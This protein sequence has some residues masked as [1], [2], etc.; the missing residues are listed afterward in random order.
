[1]I[2]C[3]KMWSDVISDHT[4]SYHELWRFRSASTKS[5]NANMDR[6]R[7]KNRNKRIKSY[8]LSNQKL[9]NVKHKS[10]WVEGSPLVCLSLFMPLAARDYRLSIDL[11]FFRLLRY[12]MIYSTC[13]QYLLN[14][15]SRSIQ[16]LLNICSKSIQDLFNIYP[17]S[18]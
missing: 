12:T 13:I 2:K 5:R 11:S 18:I 1:V 10:A 7:I 6:G 8:P 14:I 4:W 15:Y 9:K 17:V 16:D 3:D